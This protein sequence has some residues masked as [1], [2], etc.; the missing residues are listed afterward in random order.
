[1]TPPR[2]AA[3]LTNEPDEQLRGAF[4]ASPSLAG[5]WHVVLMLKTLTGH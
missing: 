1:M 3:Q 2:S 4:G 5:Y